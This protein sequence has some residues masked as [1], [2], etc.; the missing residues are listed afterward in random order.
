MLR[1]A[2]ACLVIS[3]MAAVF[4][5]G[6]VASEFD[7]IARMLFYLAVTLFVFLLIAGLRA[8]NK[9]W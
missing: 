4:G 5:F 6:G 2:L 7:D 3:I 1:L 8:G 9:L